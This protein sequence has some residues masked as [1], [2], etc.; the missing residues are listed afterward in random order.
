MPETYPTCS[1]VRYVLE[2]RLLSNLT[3]VH[4]APTFDTRDQAEEVLIE[5]IRV[6]GV[7]RVYT[8]FLSVD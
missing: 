5:S 3:H 1:K 7:S 6:F 4:S 2:E 8:I